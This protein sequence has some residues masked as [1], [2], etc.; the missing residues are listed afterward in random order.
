MGA[1]VLREL[2]GQKKNRLELK[3]LSGETGL[4][5]KISS[6]QVEI[7]S[8]EKAFWRRLSKG[9]ILIVGRDDLS[10]FA[11]A[12]IASENPVFRQLLKH[13]IPAIV[14]SEVNFLPR[15]LM[16]FSESNGI[17]LFTSNY[18]QFLLKS[19]ILGILREKIEGITALQGVFVRVFGVGVIIKGDSGLGKS[20]CALEL[21]AR[22]H[23]IVSDDLI[24]IHKKNNTAIYGQSPAISRDLMYVKGL[25]II[26]IRDLYGGKAVVDQSRVDLVVEFVEWNRDANLMG[27]D[28]A[29]SNIMDINV[30]LIRLPVRRNQMTTIIE[31]AAKRFLFEA[32]RTKNET[33]NAFE[34]I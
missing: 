7:F 33:K 28:T 20:E 2:A 5:K 4:A 31:V 24:E 29:Y 12:T 3:L 21:V 13:D 22:G 10:D 1:V 26:N 30:P 34:L 16:R 25:G 32:G 23:Q 27:H 14:F 17:P 18:D 19:R 11:A 8:T 6:S 15:H 9:S